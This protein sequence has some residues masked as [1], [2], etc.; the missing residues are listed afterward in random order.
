MPRASRPCGPRLDDLVRL[1]L[2]GA[3]AGRG[4]A[5]DAAIRLLGGLPHLG[6]QD[7]PPRRRRTPSSCSVGRPRLYGRRRRPRRGAARARVIRATIADSTAIE[8]RLGRR[9]ELDGDGRSAGGHPPRHRRRGGRDPRR[10]RSRLPAEPRPARREPHPRA[11]L[12]RPRRHDGLRHAQ[13]AGRVRQRRA[14]RGPGP[15]ARRR[16]LVAGPSRRCR[17]R[18]DP[19]PPAGGEPPR[20]AGC[21]DARSPKTAPRARR[22][23][24]GGPRAASSTSRAAD[25][26]TPSLSA[27]S[28][29]LAVDA[30]ARAAGR[31]PAADRRRSDAG[32]TAAPRRVLRP[33]P[34]GRPSPPAPLLRRSRPATPPEPPAAAPRRRGPTRGAID[35]CAPAAPRAAAEPAAPSSTPPPAAPERPDDFVDGS[36]VGRSTTTLEAPATSPPTAIALLDALLDVEVPIAPRSAAPAPR[37]RRPRRRRRPPPR[38]TAP[39][40]RAPPRAVGGAPPLTPAPPRAIIDDTRPR[41][42]A[43]QVRASPRPGPPEGVMDWARGRRRRAPTSAP[44]APPVRPAPRAPT[45]PERTGRGP[46]LPVAAARRPAGRPRRRVLRVD[47]L[48]ATPRIDAVSPA[49][50]TAGSTLTLTGAHLGET[51]AATSVSIGGRPARVVQATRRPA[52][53]RGPG[54]ADHARPRHLRAH[55]GDGGR[56]RVE[57]GQRGASTRRRA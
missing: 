30:D 11:G 31:A 23:R 2:G 17:Q 5:L 49:R 34:G 33:R 54:A 24:A 56:A 45:R 20:R 7:R 40:P 12:A 14:R 1:R 47:A 15:A 21:G 35:A 55:R 25:P 26:A 13:P 46:L 19:V 50:A 22:R 43:P 4:E 57:A 18:D 52:A 44:A 8:G 48:R 42:R 16:R 27:T 38:P 39:R 28:T 37:R 9:R 10:L 41:R 53:G 3:A 32:G 6:Q 51:A 36:R 29:G